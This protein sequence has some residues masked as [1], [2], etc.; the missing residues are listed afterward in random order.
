MRLN[1]TR[2]K[3]FVEVLMGA[4][5]VAALI[6]S[7]S[8]DKIHKKGINANKVSSASQESLRLV[9]SPPDLLSSLSSHMWDMVDYHGAGQGSHLLTIING[10]LPATAA[11]EKKTLTNATF[12]I[13]R[14]KQI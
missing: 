1:G 9:H 14:R 13:R 12:R 3:E 8:C 4:R 10:R 7:I 11:I 6:D 2:K 5:L